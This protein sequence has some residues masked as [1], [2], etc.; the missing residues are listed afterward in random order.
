MKSQA[1]NK[2]RN[3]LITTSLLAVSIP[4]LA[5]KTDTQQP[6]TVTSDNQAVDINT[7]TVTLTAAV[8]EELFI[9]TSAYCGGTIFSVNEFSALF[10]LAI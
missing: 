7:N 9:N 10:Q 4:A 8:L 1:K 3:L 2:I 6:M 5:L